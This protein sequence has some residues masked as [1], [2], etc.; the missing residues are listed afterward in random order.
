MSTFKYRAR[1]PDGRLTAGTIEADELADAQQALDERG[2]ETLLL[3]PYRGAAI[4][5]GRALSFL[6]RVSSKDLVV[7]TR[8]L[9]VM[10]SASVPIPEALRNIARQSEN[11]VLRQIML[12]VA[13][14]VEG[15]ARFSEA[16]E[17]YADV[18]S[19]FFVNMVRSGETTGQLSEVLDYL[20]DQQ[21]KDYDLQAK[22]KGAFIYPAFIIGT[23]AVMGFVM[24]TFVVPKL[25]SVLQEAGVELPWTTRSLIFVSGV[26]A[27]YWWLIVIAAIGAAAGFR[28]WIGTP[29]GRRLWD[30]AK[31]RMPLFGTLFREMYV[32][33][34][35]R[36]LGTLVK[37]GMDLVG[38]LEI[39]AAVIGNAAWHQAI[40]ETIQ[41]VNDGNSI[42]TALQR[43]SFVPTMVTQM[44]AVGESA[45][46]TQ[47]V[48]QRLTAF[49]GREIDNQVAN[50]T[51]L[52][53][54]IVLII[55]GM[56]VAVL[57]SAI[58]LPLYQLS[59]GVA[60]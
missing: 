47:D 14:D 23:M 45:G 55:L 3:E 16:L 54:P 9:S 38:A 59:S 51:K 53:E 30:L 12:T 22:I 44:L 52:I 49:Y 37:G 32:V 31:V 2:V 29:D 20:A 17:S 57:V 43:K 4:V 8:T 13:A 11:P 46:K 42:V 25:V 60:S 18:F 26:F 50:I 28:A 58:L 34:F 6:N 24:M 35:A 33:R 39:V 48:L 7:V 19:G 56:G 15:G 1:L 40:F 36:S 41:E 5:R 21:E 27:N 10:A